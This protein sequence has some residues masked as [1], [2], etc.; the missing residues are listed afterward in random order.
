MDPYT[1]PELALFGSGFKKMPTKK[2]FISKFFIY[3]FYWMY[4][5][6]DN[7]MSLSHK[8]VKVMVYLNFLL[9]DATGS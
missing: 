9:V 7:N 3:Y 5:C 6:T 4:G 1:D 2:V 8:T